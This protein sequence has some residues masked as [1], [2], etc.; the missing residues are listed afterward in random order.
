M[1]NI[2]SRKAS[3]KAAVDKTELRGPI[4]LVAIEPLYQRLYLDGLISSPFIPVEPITLAFA[5]CFDRHAE[6][7]AA[8]P[9]NTFPLVRGLL[10]W[11]GP[12][13][14]QAGCARVVLSAAK[15]NY[16]SSDA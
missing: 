8:I 4:R 14:V 6:S 13:L 16:F 1:P 15:K 3:P 7:E 5:D 10:I 9:P 11:M 2:P 12:L